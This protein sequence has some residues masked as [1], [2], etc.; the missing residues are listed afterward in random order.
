MRSLLV[1]RRQ[2]HHVA[3]VRA[4]AVGHP[5]G[6]IAVAQSI[7]RP[8]VV[9]FRLGGDA[10]GK[11]ALLAVDVLVPAHE[12]RRHRAGRNDERLRLERAEQEGQHEGHDDRFDRLAHAVPGRFWAGLG[13]ARVCTRGSV[14]FALVSRRDDR[15]KVTWIHDVLARLQFHRCIALHSCARRATNERI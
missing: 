12:R 7:A 3:A 14:A 5:D 11:P 9:H 6:G 8:L 13:T 2:G 15:V 10:I 4:D 1:L